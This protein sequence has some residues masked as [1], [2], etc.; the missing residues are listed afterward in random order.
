MRAE[1]Q[2][3]VRQIEQ[4]AEEEASYSR[5]R[6][7]QSPEALRDIWESRWK[8]SWSQQG[9][10]RSTTEPFTVPYYSL[11]RDVQTGTPSISAGG[12]GFVHDWRIRCTVI[13]PEPHVSS[14]VFFGEAYG[15]TFNWHA[16]YPNDFPSAPPLVAGEYEF[17][18]SR[19][20]DAAQE[21]PTTVDR[22]TVD[23]D[24]LAGRADSPQR[25]EPRREIRHE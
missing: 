9:L 17:R 18:W 7:G 1:L 21:A 19:I 2:S 22:V 25:L 6:F 8:G 24:F 11:V 10:V 13:S 23:R 16:R 15:G 5:T 4:R 20:G 12:S 14:R 3:L